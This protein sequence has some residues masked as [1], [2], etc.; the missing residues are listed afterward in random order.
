M[1]WRSAFSLRA[2]PVWAAVALGALFLSD[3][4]D[5]RPAYLAPEDNL[6]DTTWAL[7]DQDSA[8][9]AF[10]A[11]FAGRPTIV[12]AIYTHCPDV[13]LMTMANMRRVHA[14]LGADTA[15]VAFVTLSFDPSRDTPRVLR[16]YAATW[17]TGPDWRL[18]TGDS[19]E[20]ASLMARIG[21]RY[22]ISRR[23]TLAS[24]DAIYSI[25]H[26]DKAL[27]LDAD[28]QVV[29]TYGGSAAPPEQV[30]ADARALL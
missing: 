4:W 20:V 18:L 15:R 29:E 7:V 13:C 1:T 17:R 3:L 12:S 11:H 30:A 19:T 14:A 24:G 16:N 5:R 27:L 23:D 9:V 21:V 22:E 2:L 6:A 25:S 26:T 8:A 10:P 28:G